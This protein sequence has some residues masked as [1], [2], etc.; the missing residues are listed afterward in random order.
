[1]TKSRAGLSD[2]KTSLGIQFLRIKGK[3]R[4][5][6]EAANMFGSRARENLGHKSAEAGRASNYESD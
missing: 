4:Q 5:R 6:P 3:R 2:T 1:M